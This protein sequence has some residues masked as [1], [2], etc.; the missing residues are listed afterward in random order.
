MLTNSLIQIKV[1][2]VHKLF[3]KFSLNVLFLILIC[4]KHSFAANTF[5][6]P[7]AGTVSSSA[8]KTTATKK[9]NTSCEVKKKISAYLKN[10]KLFFAKSS[11]SETEVELSPLMKQLL[12]PYNLQYVTLTG[13]L[14]TTGVDTNKSFTYA[15]KASD[16]LEKEF[17]T[18][19]EAAVLNYFNQ[20]EIID[21]P[22]D[23]VFEK[24]QDRVTFQNT[25]QG[26]CLVK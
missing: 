10:Q 15:F 21:E 24:K 23:Q 3:F 4:S 25:F 16:Q 11:L 20:Y 19:P 1:N 14:F 13:V 6:K 12:K 5:S 8:S 22:N 2:L 18:K 17:L 7:Q 9:Q 26:T